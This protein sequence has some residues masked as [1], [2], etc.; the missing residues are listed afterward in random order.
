MVNF[1]HFLLT[2]TTESG[3]TVTVVVVANDSTEAITIFL[4]TYEGS[5]SIR[6]IEVSLP[7]LII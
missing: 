1:T 5:R 6:K 2:V 4:E 3:N 7:L